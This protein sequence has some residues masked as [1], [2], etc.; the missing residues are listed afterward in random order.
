MT[1]GADLTE[2]PVLLA[3]VILDQLNL[4]T[5]RHMKEPNQDQNCLAMPSLNCQSRPVSKMHAYHC[6]LLFGDGLLYVIVVA[7]VN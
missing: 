1:H 7:T 2:L 6:K 5:A 3:K 4:L